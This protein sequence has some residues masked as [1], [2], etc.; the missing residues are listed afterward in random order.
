MSK[1]MNRLINKFGVGIINQKLM[2]LNEEKGIVNTKVN[3][4]Y[5]SLECSACHYIDKRNRNGEQFKCLCCGKTHHADINSTKNIIRRSD[6]NRIDI[7][8]NK[9]KILQLL[10]DDFVT[11]KRF[12]I[13]SLS[14]AVFKKNKYVNVYAS[15]AMSLLS[16]K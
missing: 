6:D 12:C 10:V 11:N 4:A 2:N 15:S 8:T 9:N 3:P 13:S 16:I 1:R 7:Y 14:S 5:T